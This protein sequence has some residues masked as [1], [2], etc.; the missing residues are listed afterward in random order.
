MV[1]TLADAWRLD[2]LYR[3]PRRHLRGKD[4]QIEFFNH[5]GPDYAE[6]DNYVRQFVNQIRKKLRENPARN[7]RYNINE[8]G[9]GYRFVD[10]E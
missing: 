1:L 2:A 8:P 9:V 3:N 6:M 10:I 5:T 7:I 4:A